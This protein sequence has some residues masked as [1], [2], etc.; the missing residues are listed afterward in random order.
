MESLRADYALRRGGHEAISASRT[1]CCIG[2]L[3]WRPLSVH[4]T[5]RATPRR[6]LRASIRLEKLLL[7]KNAYLAEVL[8]VFRL[9]NGNGRFRLLLQNSIRAHVEVEE[10]DAIF[11]VAFANLP[12]DA[13]F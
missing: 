8:R 10:K 4:G 2:S 9:D 3:V 7:P 11:A 12:F 5:G 6:A 13:F 1:A